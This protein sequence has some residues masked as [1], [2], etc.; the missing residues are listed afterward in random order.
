MKKNKSWNS[1][2]GNS[3]HVRSSFWEADDSAQKD[4]ERPI[5]SKK[6]IPKNY[7]HD[8]EGDK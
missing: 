7:E 3:T 4:C 8:D 2:K 5:H 6:V 1:H